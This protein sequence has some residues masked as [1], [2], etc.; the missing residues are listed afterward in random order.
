MQSPEKKTQLAFVEDHNCNTVFPSK[1]TISFSFYQSWKL[2]G[3]ECG[4][5]FS[6]EPGSEFL[7][8][9]LGLFKDTAWS[10]QGGLPCVHVEHGRCG[11]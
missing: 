11:S 6:G 1:H 5:M 2:V 10:A 8:Q 4:I 9:R 3:G 7:L